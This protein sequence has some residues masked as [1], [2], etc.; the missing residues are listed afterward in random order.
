MIEEWYTESAEN[1]RRKLFC[2]NV[3]AR[4]AL[5]T[6]QS[7]RARRRIAS[8]PKTSARNDVKREGR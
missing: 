3:I 6:K 2:K 7:P 1:H 8:P 4:R 5:T